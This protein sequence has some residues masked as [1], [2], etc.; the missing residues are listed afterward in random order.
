MRPRR[1]LTLGHSYAVALN[2]RLP[3]EMALVGGGK[4][5]VTVAAP[6][7]VHGDLREVSL[8]QFEGEASR[9][10]PVKLYCSRR[11][12]VM[13]YGQT[14]RHLLREEWDIIHCWEE[15]YILCGAQV[16]RRSGPGR[17]V[18][19][20]FQ[21]LSKRY[22]P[23]Y[24]WIE[25]YSI[26]RA[27]GWIAAGVT[28]EETLNRRAGYPGKPH[29][30][31]PLGVEIEAFRPDP[32]ARVATRQRL[33]WIDSGPPVVGYLGRFV[34]EKGLGLL[35]TVLGDVKAP[36]R[37]LFVGGGALESELRAWA[38]RFPDGRVRIVTGVPHDEVPQYLSA[39]DVLAAPSQTT[40]RWREQLG[41]MLIE[42]MA[43]G[44]P[45]VGSDSGEIPYVIG[46][47]GE[48]VHESEV[49]RWTETLGA[50]LENSGR[51]E[52][53]GKAGRE[54]A[55]TQFSW[56]IVGRKHLEFF[57]EILGD[58]GIKTS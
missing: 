16:A 11:P 6:T 21:N 53:L 2:R 25:R 12:H 13:L 31:I 22:L 36:W 55:E 10:I 1:L 15:P 41:R 24:R 56:P 3:H 19:Y 34:A 37:A 35:T 44:V 4:W 9:L 7:F 28:V 48:I 18:Y 40:P 58:T 45:V 50:L 20:S 8:E 46:D 23:P 38:A 49:E 42:A 17:V 43:C 51:R 32:S 52:E 54:R 29:C 47:A 33:G 27:A 26:R 57:E 30:V 39:M 14:L 5:D